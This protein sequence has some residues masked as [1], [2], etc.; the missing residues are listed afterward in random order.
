MNHKEFINAHPKKKMCFEYALN[1]PIENGKSFSIVLSNKSTDK[2][3]RI[4]I[5]KCFLLEIDNQTKKCD[6]GFIRCSNSEFYF[7]ELKGS[8][9]GTAVKQLLVTILY[10]RKEYAVKPEQTYAYIASTGL[11]R[12][13]N[14]KFQKLQENFIKEKIGVELKKQTNHYQ[15]YI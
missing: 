3:L 9:I 1:T 13:A 6:Y 5:D 11:P 8:D 10:F 15:H 12:A 4:K 14:Q 7:V 2:F